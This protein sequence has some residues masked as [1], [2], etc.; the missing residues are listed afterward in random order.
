[1]K[2][3]DGAV[4]MAADVSFTLNENIINEAVQGITN[5]LSA[6]SSEPRVKRV[7][8]T[9]ARAAAMGAKPGVPYKIELDT[10][11]D[12]VFEELKLPAETQDPQHRGMMIYE[13]AKCKAEQAAFEFMREHKP[14]F[15]FNSVL[16]NVNFGRTV[17]VEHLGFP[18]GSSLISTLDQGYPLGPAFILNQWFVNTEDMALLHL[19]AL[20][21]EDVVSERIPA[22][23]GP[24]SWKEIIAILCRRFPDRKNMVTDCAD[25][26]VDIGEVDNARA[27]ELL[28]K[29]GRNGFKSLEDSLVEA[30]QCVI[31][32]DA[33][34]SVPRTLADDMVDMVFKSGAKS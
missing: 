29:M 30:M 7:V 17:A 31:A 34:P 26:P 22:M 1:M 5:I 6:A 25:A 15:V 4:H 3:V 16:P 32:A 2:G 12:E 18:S 10:W 23:A 27:A 8:L 28:R 24:F 14:H 20:T 19:A 21:L 33:L 9:S 11:N 13:A